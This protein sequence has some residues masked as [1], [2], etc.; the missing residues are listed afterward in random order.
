LGIGDWGLG[1]GDWGLGIGPNPQ[2]PIPNPQSP[3][4]NENILTKL[5]LIKIKINIYEQYVYSFNNK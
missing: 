4:P 3:I 5:F 2:S 1:I